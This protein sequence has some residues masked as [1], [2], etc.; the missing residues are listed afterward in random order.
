VLNGAV[1]AQIDGN[2]SVRAS[3]LTLNASDNSQIGAYAMAG[4]LTVTSSPLSNAFGGAFV[5]AGT[6]N[7]I[8]RPVSALIGDPK[9][10]TPGGGK[11]GSTAT[12]LTA[13]R[14]ASSRIIAD[15]AGA[16]LSFERSKKE[17]SK[18]IGASFAGGFAFNEI[19]GDITAGIY[20]L[21]DYSSSGATTI[22]ATAMGSI[23]SF[24]GGFAVSVNLSTKEGGKLAAGGALGLAVSRNTIN[25]DVR[26][27]IGK[28]SIDNASKS[29]QI[30]S[31]TINSRDERQLNTQATGDSL[32]LS[33]SG[34][35]AG[36]V[37]VGAAQ[38][39][40]TINAAVEAIVDLASDLL[41]DL[42]GDL[43]VTA[44]DLARIET[45]VLAVALTYA[46][47]SR[48][49]AL[50]GGGAGSSNTITAPVTARVKAGSVRSAKAKPGS[51]T[52]K[53]ASGETDDKGQVNRSRE[54]VA[55]LG[56]GSL[57]VARGRSASS[58]G[59][60]IG[61]AD[62]ANSLSGDVAAALEADTV[63][64]PGSL[65]V[66]STSADRIDTTVA[67][68]SMAVGVSKTDANGVAAAL[69][70]AGA[71]ARNTLDAAS[72]ALVQRYDRSTT[73]N[74]SL[75]LGG[76]LKLSSIAT[77]Q[78]TANVGSGSLA[79]SYAG[80]GAA[81]SLAPSV[82]IALASNTLNGNGQAALRGFGTVAVNARSARSA[83]C[84]CAR[85][86]MSQNFTAGSRSSR[87]PAST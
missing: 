28:L 34:G 61:A 21:T 11:V 1:T 19:I 4:A 77:G 51:T 10:I 12:T 16:A 32:T 33:R 57:A 67:A 71:G 58:F 39:S 44:T 85:P 80:Q 35:N 82:G 25:G 22:S 41:L 37:G 18:A 52:I 79:V 2:S 31:L 46:E 84:T 56:A 75:T 74:G 30:G 68:A 86:W 73:A 45:F 60:S 40:N 36:A 42:Q 81:S 55:R 26:A 14:G 65:A 70:G 76:G 38:S 7:T 66:T 64:L 53:A 17:G 29:L 15:A 63:D 8:D 23:A 5:G 43:S 48:G 54:L 50:A 47:G 27:G 6:G 9:A 83:T 72:T 69:S 24:A 49:I 87:Q 78:I 3:D 20:N 62:V 59:A 13:E